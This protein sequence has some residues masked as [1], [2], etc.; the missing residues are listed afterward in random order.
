MGCGLA[1]NSGLLTEESLLAGE[2]LDRDK[3]NREKDGNNMVTK[4]QLIEFAPL[5]TDAFLAHDW[6]L[7][8]RDNHAYVIKIGRGRK[9][10][11]YEAFYKCKYN[12]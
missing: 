3:Y 12:H 2:K 5:K 7:E 9:Y 8:G 1:G 10:I 4:K 6:G 11:L